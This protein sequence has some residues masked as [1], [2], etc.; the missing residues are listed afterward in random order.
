MRKLLL[1]LAILIITG[2]TIAQPQR[3]ADRPFDRHDERREAIEARRISYLTQKLALTTEEA[4]M[5][6]PVYHEYNQKVEELS[7]SFRA[8]REQMP[9]ISELNEEEAATF[10]EEELQRFENAAALRREYTEKMLDIISAKK[11]ALLFEAEK[12]FN[13]MLFRE[14]QRR[15]RHDNRMRD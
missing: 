6:W 2:T 14:A 12:S 5:F 8:K 13:R 11:V 9:E 1:A 4:K 15:Q 7:G 3:G 10:V